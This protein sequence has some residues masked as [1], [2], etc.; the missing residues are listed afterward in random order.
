MSKENP[1]PCRIKDGH[2]DH[3]PAPARLGSDSCR[4]P[5]RHHTPRSPT[6][7]PRRGAAAPRLLPNA[8]R[9]TGGRTPPR[10]ASTTWPSGRR[11]RVD[12][13][14]SNAWSSSCSNRTRSTSASAARTSSTRSG[15]SGPVTPSATLTTRLLAVPTGLP[16]ALGDGLAQRRT[17]TARSPTARQ[18]CCSERPRLFRIGGTDSMSRR[19]TRTGVAGVPPSVQPPAPPRAGGAWTSTRR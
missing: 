9:R 13:A 3:P 1:G 14:R 19:A 11:S 2:P 12:R 17:S 15:S 16:P 4:S 18:S 7:A 10:Q 6:P 8:H 5:P